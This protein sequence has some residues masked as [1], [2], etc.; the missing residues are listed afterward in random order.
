[1]K[2]FLPRIGLTF[3]VLQSVA[4]VPS[5]AQQNNP[6]PEASA[7]KRD[8][9]V[10]VLSP[11]V[12]S[13][14]RDFG[15]TATS[16]LAGGRLATDL[17]KTPAAISV[18]TREFL[19]DIG[20]TDIQGALAWGT[21]TGAAGDSDVAANAT[22]GDSVNGRP[23]TSNNSNSV[24][25]RGFNNVTVARNYF[26]WFVNS[27]SYNTERVDISRGPNA[28]IFGDASSGGIVNVTTKR[29]QF[30]DRLDFSMRVT[31]VGGKR[32]TV[33][34][35]QA[36]SKTLAIRVNGL[37]ERSESWRDFSRNDRDGLF[38]TVMWNPTKSLQVRVD[39]E[40]GKIDRRTPALYLLDQTSNWNGTYTISSRLT[41]TSA[42]PTSA[43]ASRLD[44]G[45]NR[46]L[47]YLIIDLANPGLGFVDWQG[48]VRSNGL[49]IPIEPR[50]PSSQSSL[51]GIPI[52]DVAVIGQRGFRIAPDYAY[53][54]NVAAYRGQ[55]DYEAYSA[56][57]EKRFG[58]HFFIEAAGTLQV[59]EYLFHAPASH[60]RVYLDLNSQLPAG[61][62]ING[63][64]TNP[65]F[66]KPYVQGTGIR[67]NQTD[68][69]V[70]EAR[71]S[72]VYTF[73]TALTKQR[74]GLLLSK[75]RHDVETVYPWL[76]RVNGTNPNLSAPEN[77]LYFRT[78][79]D[80]GRELSQEPYSLG[81]D[82]MF[83]NGVVGRYE[84]WNGSGGGTTTD[85]D[86]TSAQIF[87]SGSWLKSERVSTIVGIRR[88]QAET[89]RNGA[90]FDSVTQRM[91]G[92]AFQEQVEAK[93]N[94]PSAGMVVQITPSVAVYGNFSRT[95]FA[96][97][98]NTTD[99]FGTILPVRRGEGRDVG[100]K[101]T[102]FGKVSG[103]IGYYSTEEQNTA[104][105][106]PT[107]SDAINDI[108]VDL[109]ATV[110]P[111]TR[112]NDTQD[113]AATGYE[114][115]LTANLTRSWTLLFNASLPE[116]ELSNS[117]PRY[118][119]YVNENRAAWEAAANNPANPDAAAIRNNLAT[120]DAELARQADGLPR[121]D[122]VNFLVNIFSRYR[123]STGVL[124]GLEFGGGANFV[125][126]RLIALD[127]SQNR[128][129]SDGFST[130][131]ALLA[132]SKKWRGVDWRLQLNVSNLLDDENFRY[133]SLLASGVPQQYRISEPRVFSLTTSAKF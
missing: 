109:G 37:L 121:A 68:T 119:G 76:V 125:G 87:A 128:I 79:L 32:F 24:K 14:Q 66:L 122:N 10:M 67:Y 103:S 62:T 114:L 89:V 41:G 84:V 98:G 27:D 80:N 64:N 105:R 39:A 19:D 30:R 97:T 12:V 73:E 63:S 101:F 111:L 29:A 118:R 93:V 44:T 7:E 126:R 130:V 94:S 90:T 49:N 18:L 40:Y 2:S 26:P 51:A 88:D 82:H 71:V 96:P 15:Y 131:S 124:K 5:S 56:F 99:I 58:S 77:R 91:N 86:L 107:I 45:A 42:P 59:Q 113:V 70:A 81:Q 35:N 108:A 60:N 4:L 102:L 83:S 23:D 43:G 17:Q 117:L 34:A 33:D 116:S 110:L 6:Q 115:D 53:S 36:I 52:E 48:S 127:A 72:A 92:Y 129:H 132:Y 8:D 28:L 38:G 95:F 123:V 16:S 11:F 85:L 1:M 50:L 55:A 75:R 78:Y 120:I 104:I 133:S 31:D 25:I 100:L 112:D 21:N 3:V 13:T 106:V 57:V 54:A 65:N 69:T 47:P 22:A 46:N 20:V 9:E 74:I 61:V